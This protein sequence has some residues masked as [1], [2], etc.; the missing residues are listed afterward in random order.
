MEIFTFI[1]VFIVVL[2]AFL[3]CVAFFVLPPKMKITGLPDREDFI[4]PSPR[5]SFEE[6]TKD[7][8]RA[9]SRIDIITGEIDCAVYDKK[10]TASEKET[11]FDCLYQKLKERVD[12]HIYCSPVITISNGLKNYAW[13]IQPD[14]SAVREKIQEEENISYK[15]MIRIS[16]LLY[17]V[18]KG[19]KHEDGTYTKVK[20]HALNDEPY[21]HYRIIDGDTS[22]PK[23]YVEYHHPP[24]MPV[25]QFYT[26]EN[27]ILKIK[28]YMTK[29]NDLMENSH[30]CT[31]EGDVNIKFRILY[32]RKYHDFV[33]SDSNHY[34]G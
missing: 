33:T 16:G 11:I 25:K 20:L 32:R 19:Y 6:F 31:E 30:L 23:L 18:L 4:N 24:L 27:S 7:I 5:E 1:A 15:E 8:K 10:D 26:V 29:R 12:V 13:L 28:K 14:F 3:P 2:L 34:G 21:R 22:H 9:S 17:L